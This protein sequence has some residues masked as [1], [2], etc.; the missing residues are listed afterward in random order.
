M[1]DRHAPPKK[2]DE[3][4]S[5]RKRNVINPDHYKAGDAYEHRLV[6]RAWRLSYELGCATKYICRAGK[7]GIADPI[8]DLRKAI[9]YIEFE[10]EKLEDERL[11]HEDKDEVHK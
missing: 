8:E 10:I 6:V 2:D 1:K 11:S 7:K 4:W 3:D 9:R 5:L